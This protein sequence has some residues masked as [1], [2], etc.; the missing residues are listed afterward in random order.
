MIFKIRPRQ[1]RLQAIFTEIL[2]MTDVGLNWSSMSIIYNYLQK[3]YLHR[4]SQTPA[5]DCR[6]RLLC[7]QVLSLKITRY[8]RSRLLGIVAQDCSVRR[9]C[10][11]RSCPQVLS[12]KIVL[13]AGIVA[14]DCSVHRYCRSRLLCPQVLSLKIVLS[15]GVVAQ[16]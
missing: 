7:P 15:A 12:L 16:D 2:E 4:V 1:F 8:C 10:R 5:Q 3:L 6:S 11:S 13:S 9:Y 14:Q